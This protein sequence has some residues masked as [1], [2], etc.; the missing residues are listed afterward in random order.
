LGG[1]RHPHLSP[2][3]PSKAPESLLEQV[4]VRLRG[5]PDGNHQLRE[6]K[7]LKAMN[8]HRAVRLFQDIPAY[9]DDVVRPDPNQ[10][11]VERGVMESAEGDAIRD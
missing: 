3:Q 7:P 10:I 6:V 1:R 8:Q 11:G 4:P 9:F 5:L 2:S